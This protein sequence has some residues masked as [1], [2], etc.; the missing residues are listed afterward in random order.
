VRIAW[1]E[2]STTNNS[3]ADELIATLAAHPCQ[4]GDSGGSEA[5][6]CRLPV[7]LLAQLRRCV[8]K[9]RVD[10]RAGDRVPFRTSTGTDSPGSI[11]ATTAEVPVTTPPLPDD[12]DLV[13]GAH[14]KLVTDHQIV[15]RD[16]HLNSV[17]QQ[18]Y[19]LAPNSMPRRWRTPSPRIGTAPSRVCQAG[20]RALRDQR[21]RVGAR[22]L[23]Q[24]IRRGW[25]RSLLRPR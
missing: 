15:D 24:P 18:R 5:S 17:A 8:T 12:G 1:V 6:A 2:S 25:R 9:P 14:Y 21:R 7:E 3:W 4:P 11:E 19:S 22:S 20:R 13:A 16:S 23:E 10:G